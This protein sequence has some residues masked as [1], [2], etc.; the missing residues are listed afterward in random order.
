LLL[1]F[2]AISAK[3]S[4]AQACGNGGSGKEGKSER[5]VGRRRGKRALIRP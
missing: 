5:L 4:L 3:R 2:L 1:L